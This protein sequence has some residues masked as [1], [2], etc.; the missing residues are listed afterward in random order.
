MNETLSSLMVT[1]AKDNRQLRSLMRLKS[2]KFNE[3]NALLEQKARNK[4]P[5]DE[6]QRQNF[7]EFMRL[8][9]QEGGMLKQ[10][11][12]G[13]DYTLRTKIDLH[14]ENLEA[15]LQSMT[16]LHGLQVTAIHSLRRLI[17]SSENVL[18]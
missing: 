5:L 13:L 14:N 7:H 11:L 1:T 16:A 18:E 4:T 15:L 2:R 9:A 10:T 12:V 8:Y 17:A 3:V 6:R